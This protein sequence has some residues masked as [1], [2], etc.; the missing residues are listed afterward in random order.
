MAYGASPQTD[1]SDAVRALVGDVGTSTS[2]TYLDDAEYDF[3]IAETASKY[4]AA[5]LAANALAGLFAGAAA[6]ASGSGYVEKTVG[7]LKIKK[8][9][10]VQIAAGY[11]AMAHEFGIRAAAGISPYA[12]GISA[13][14]KDAVESDTDR[15]RPSFLRGL[16]ENPNVTEIT[17]GAGST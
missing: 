14:D 9:D 11:R 2:A 7:D 4:S 8:S 16:Y 1:P 13:S 15:V 10:A 6:S 12:G 5:A 17:S 3:F